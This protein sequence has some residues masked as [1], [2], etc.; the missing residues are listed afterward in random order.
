[1][2]E[3]EVAEAPAEAPV[4]APVVEAPPESPEAAPVEE[5]AGETVEAEAEGTQVDLGGLLKSLTAAEFD[6]LVKEADPDVL[7]NSSFVAEQR[8]RGEQRAM[9]REKEQEQAR[10]TQQDAYSGL[11]NVG[12]EAEDAL[13]EALDTASTLY[14]RLDRLA[15]DDMADPADVRKTTQQLAALLPADGVRG[16]VGAIRASALAEAARIQVAEVKGHIRQHADLLGQ[17]SEDE[18]KE[19]EGL[20]YDDAR[21]GKASS[22][23]RLIDILTDRA[24]EKGKVEGEERGANSKAATADLLEKAKNIARVKAGAAP[25]TP[26]GG[27][28]SGNTLE[29]WE[30]RVAHQGEDGYPMLTDADW[31]QYRAVRRQHGL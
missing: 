24:Y 29:A 20:A 27:A 28:P 17:L 13:E 3:V 12:R 31:D 15:A 1:M 25:L 26:E 4:E 7:E 10:T 11:I 21:T 8:R 19:L 5:A 9:T 18:Q 22:I 6:A 2:P 30:T 16:A 23:G 14:R